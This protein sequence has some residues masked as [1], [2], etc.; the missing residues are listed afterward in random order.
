[1]GT[2]FGLVFVPAG[3]LSVGPFSVL[4][5]VCVGVPMHCICIKDM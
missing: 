5:V 2:A 1:M 4:C 3:G